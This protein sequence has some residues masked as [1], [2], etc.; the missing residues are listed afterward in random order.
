MLL[1]LSFFVF[2]I[3]SHI[4]HLDNLLLQCRYKGGYRSL[5]LKELVLT[6]LLNHKYKIFNYNV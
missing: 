4:R 2:K 5:N 3:K 6:I 1:T